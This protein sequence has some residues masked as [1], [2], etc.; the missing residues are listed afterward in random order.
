MPTVEKK[1]R[2]DLT[3][4]LD[5]FLA[6]KR[7]E[8]SPVGGDEYDPGFLNIIEFVERFKLLPNGLYPVQRFILK[9]YYGLKL[10]DVLPEKTSDRISVSKTY[11]RKSAVYMTEV[12]YLAWLFSQGR[13]NIGVQDGKVRKELIL[14]IGRRSGKSTLSSLIASYELYKL[15]RRGYPQVYYGMPPGSD[16]RVLCVANDK[17]QA[18]IVFQE[19]KGYMNQVDYFKSSS[20]HDTQ[21]YVQFRSES[22]RKRF[23]DAGKAT[24]TA[25][26]NSCVAKGLRGRGIICVILDEFA[27]FVDESNKS[28]AEAVYRALTPATRQFTPR[29]PSDRRVAIGPSDGR[30]IVISSP[31]AKDGY[32]YSLYNTAISGGKAGANMLMIQAPTWEVRPDLSEEDYEVD[33]AKDPK[34]FDTEFGAQ[35]SDRVRGWIEVERDLTD[36]II[37]DLKPI[38]RGQPRE[39]FF[40]GV[41]FALAGDGTAVALTHL[42]DGRIQLAYH[43]TWRA[44]KPWRDLNPH[45]E[46]FPT[47]YAELLQTVKRLDID[48]VVAW[49]LALS[50]RFYMEKG[51]FDQW[52]GIIFEQKLHKLGLT[53]FESRKFSD[54][55]SSNAYS[56]TKSMLFSKMIGLYDYPLPEAK[57]DELGG[58]RHSPHIEEILELQATSGGKNVIVVEAPQVAGKHDDFSDAWIRSNLL[59]AEYVRAHPVAL[60]AS[61][62]S[63]SSPELMF[64]KP[65]SWLQHQRERIRMHGPPPRERT[66]PRNILRRR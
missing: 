58:S 47:P 64:P 51:V 11:H 62:V 36:C 16:I 20:A 31:D 13:C 24:I 42:V 22:D 4:A 3:G 5:E 46:T 53:Q 38:M 27:F 56:I 41:D 35:F 7:K 43:E 39:L 17:N 65:T 8:K 61:R 23:G 26:F 19:M 1:D 33:Y 32:F 55:D 12:E 28:S 37:K 57:F 66:V 18:S 54:A 15:L 29:D 6:K 44:G 49:I 25:A 10:D 50:K 21:T 45:L 60:D 48:E 40:C 34:S 9:M 52:A 2:S 30:I 14:V 59:A 63:P